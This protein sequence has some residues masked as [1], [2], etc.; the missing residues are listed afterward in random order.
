VLVSSALVRNS[1]ISGNVATGSAVDEGRGGGVFVGPDGDLQLTATTVT[2]NS[3]AGSGGG[4]YDASLGDA[5]IAS[6]IVAGNDAPA[7][8][9]CSVAA[10]GVPP[11]QGGNVFG[12]EGC[13]DPRSSDILTADP[14]LGP[15]GDNGGTTQTHALLPGSPAIGNGLDLGLRID[16]RGVPRGTDPDSGSYEVPE[17]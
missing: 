4:I 8:A 13:G 10:P 5:A 11:S 12:T 15:L 3:A 9:D 1:T 2:D 17:P 6:S 7:G 16:Q 14:G